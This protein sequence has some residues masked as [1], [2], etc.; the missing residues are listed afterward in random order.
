MH[1]SINHYSQ[2]LRNGIDQF[3]MMCIQCFFIIP[4]IACVLP[5]QYCI[6]TF[7]EILNSNILIQGVSS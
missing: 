5:L 4:C 6:E 3:E 1:T 2:N 7:V